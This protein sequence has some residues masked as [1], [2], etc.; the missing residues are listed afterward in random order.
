MWLLCG[1]AAAMFIFG[2]AMTYAGIFDAGFDAAGYPPGFDAGLAILAMAGGIG[3]LFRRTAGWSALGLMVISLSAAGVYYL[4][5]GFV[6][7]FWPIL[8][9][10]L[11]LVIMLGRGLP[12]RT[13][14]PD[15]AGWLPMPQTA[16]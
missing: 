11:L 10:S 1:I 5:G 12:I 7:M 6:S 15:P 13:K 16:S 2:G 8:A 9:S 4:L 3:L 14:T